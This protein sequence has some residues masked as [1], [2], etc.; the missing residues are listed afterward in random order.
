[1]ATGDGVAQARTTGHETEQ[2]LFLRD[3]EEKGV[4]FY[5]V[6]VEKM[7]HGRLVTAASTFQAS[8]VSHDLARASPTPRSTSKALP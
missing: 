2:G 5:S 3:L 4:L 8:T 7:I 6:S 1:M